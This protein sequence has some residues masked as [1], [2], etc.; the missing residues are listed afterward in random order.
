MTR[1]TTCSRT[2]RSSWRG[3]P[4]ATTTPELITA[5]LA[6]GGFT[7]PTIESVELRSRAASAADA[8]RAFC[9]GTP[10]RHD[11]EAR[12]PA[13]LAELFDRTTALI[14]ERFGATDVDAPMRALVVTV[15]A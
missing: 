9:Y 6:A 3:C 15:D 10:T 1:S 12:D 2:R 11:V 8:A 14:T 5:D 7:D 13:A 4:T